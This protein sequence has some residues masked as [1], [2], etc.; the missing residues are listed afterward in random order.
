[1]AMQTRRLLADET[2]RM[3][4]VAAGQKVLADNRGALQQHETLLVSLVQG[5]I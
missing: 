1:L 5:L 3:D 2:L 4:A